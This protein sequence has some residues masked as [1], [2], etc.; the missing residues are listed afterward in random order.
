LKEFKEQYMPISINKKR[1]ILVWIISICYLIGF[2]FGVRATLAMLP[3]Y[4]PFY[5]ILM[6]IVALLAC[7]SLFR[8]KAIAAPLISVQLVLFVGGQWRANWVYI[9]DTHTFI[10]FLVIFSFCYYA[11]Y[12]KI[13]K[14]LN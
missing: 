2:Y 9:N 5:S 13:T 12:L 7:V 11:W 14:V 3:K 4:L 6:S 8:L 10:V 1:P